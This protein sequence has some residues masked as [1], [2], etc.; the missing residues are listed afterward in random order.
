M[1][2]VE[3]SHAGVSLGAEILQAIVDRKTALYLSGGKTPKELY[4]MLSHEEKIVP[5]AVG[6]VDE[7]YGQ[8]FHAKSNEVMIRETGLVRYLEMRDVPFYPILTGHPGLD[9]DERKLV[10]QV[11]DDRLRSLNAILQKSVAVLG[12]GSDGHTAGIAG[13][14]QNFHNP[15]FDL[16]RKHLLISEFNDEKGDF[17]ERVTMTFLGLSMMDVLLILV[18]GEDKK[19]ALELM[20]QSGSEEEIPARFYKRSEVAFRTII[21]TDQ[22]V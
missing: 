22:V 1:C 11:Y 9:K 16:D 4:A 10:T 17:K 3:D 8:K 2:F 6:M 7:R 21:L 20:F 12:I 15:L 19:H 14:R 18:F 5:G 13:N